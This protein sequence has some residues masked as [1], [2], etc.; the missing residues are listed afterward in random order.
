MASRRSLRRQQ[1]E[2]E[3]QGRRRSLRLARQKAASVNY[4]RS[5][6]YQAPTNSAQLDFATPRTIFKKVLQTQ[7]IVSPLVS[8]KPDSPKPIDTTFNIPGKLS[9]SSIN[10]EVSLPSST[11]RQKTR[12]ARHPTRSKKVRLSEFERDLNNQLHSST[13]QDLLDQTSLTK[14]LQISFTTPIPLNSAGRKGLARYRSV[15]VKDF[16]GGL[17]QGLL[18]IKDPANN[19]EDQ[20]TTTPQS[21]NTEAFS[22]ETELFLPP[23]SS[24][25]CDSEPSNV[26]PELDLARKPL[27]PKSSPSLSQPRLAREDEISDMDVETEAEVV[28]PK[29]LTMSSESTVEAEMESTEKED[30]PREKCP[31]RPPDAGKGSR[32]SLGKENLNPGREDAGRVES[33]SQKRIA[34]PQKQQQKPVLEN[35]SDEELLIPA[36]I[37]TKTGLG[38]RRSSTPTDA[39]LPR[40]S[41]R[42]FSTWLSRKITRP[43][44]DEMVAQF[45]KELDSIFPAAVRQGV[46]EVDS[47]EGSSLREITVDISQ[48]PGV[49]TSN[50]RASGK[51]PEMLEKTPF[52]AVG[53]RTN[54]QTGDR[55]TTKEM[56]NVETEPILEFEAIDN[57][58]FAT[59]VSEDIAVEISQS[60]IMAT[61]SR[62]ASGRDSKRLEGTPFTSTRDRANPQT[63]DRNRRKEMRSVETAQMLE[64]E[65]EDNPEFEEMSESED[66]AVEIPQSPRVATSGRRASG[67]DSKR[68]EGT[69]FTST[70]DRTN[71]HTG[72]RNRRKE[73]RSVETEQ[74]LEVEAEGNPEFEMSESEDVAVEIRQSPRVATS[75]RRASGRDSKRL[76][77]T[78]FT[79]TRDRTNPHTGDRNRRK[80][81]RNVE[82][83]QILEFEPESNSEVEEMSESVDVAV[84]IRQSPR[85]STS[86][87]RASG[88]DSKR[89]EGT[90]FTSTRDRTNPQTGDRSRT[91]GM[92]NVETEQMLEF[93]AEDNPESEE[94]SESEDVAV[95]IPQRPRVATS[96]RRASG[97]DSKRLEGTPFTSTRDRTNPQTGDRNRR[98]EMRN[99]ETEQILEFEAEENP[100]F[101]EMSES[102]DVAVDIPQRPRVATSGRRAS[103]RDSKRLEGTPFT[104]TRD[105]TNPHTA[106]EIPQSPIM[107]TSGRRASGRD[108]KRLEGTPFTS[109]RDRTNPQTGDRNRRKEMRNV[110]TEQVLEVE[111]ESNPEFEEMSESEDVAVD[112]PQSPRV[113]TSGRRASGRDSKKL[114]GTFTSA[115]DRT[116]PH[117]AVEIPQSPRVATSGRRASGRDSKRLEGTPFTSTRDRTNPHTGDRNRRKEMRSVETEQMLEVEAEGNPEFEM[118]ESEDVAV[119]IPQSPR[120]ATSGRR[121]SG[122]DS[123]KLEGTFTSARDRTNP[124]TAVEIPQSPRVA[125]SGRRAS[126]RDSKRL[127]GTPFTST[128]DRTNPHTGDRNRRKEMRSV[129]TEQMLEVEAEGNPEFEMSESEDVA[130]EIRQSPRVST[131]GRR[132]SGRDSK[133]LEGTPFTSTRDRTNPQTG[134]RSRTA[135]MR[136]VETE[137]ML[138]FEPESNSEVEEM[139]ESEDVAVE[140]P[141]SPRVATSGKRASG[142]DSKR[143]ERTPFTSTRD[144]TNPQTGDRN[145]RKEMRNVETEQMLEVEA[146]SNPE[147]E[148]M[149]ESEDVAVEIRQSPRVATS[150]RRASGRDSKRLEGTP[151]TS[152]RD[153]TNPHTGDRN[154]RKEMRSVETAQILVFEAEDNPEF[155]MSESEDVAV[156]I[157]QSPRVATSGRR[158]SGRDSKRL[159]GTLLKATRDRTNPQTADRNRRKEMRNVETAQILVFE[160]KDNPE[161]EMSES[162]DVAVEFPQSPRVATSGRR[163]SGRDSKRL[164]GIPF[165]P[166]RGRTNPQTGDRNRRK[167]MRSVETEQILEFEAE[168]NSDVEEMSESEDIEPMGST[169]A[170]V[171]AKAFHCTPLLSSPR[172]LKEVA[173]PG[174]PVKQNSVQRVLKPAKKASRGKRE[175][176][177]PRNLVKKMFSHYVKMPV[178]KEAFQVMD[179]CVNVYFKHLSSD[180]EAYVNHARRKTAEAADLELL[181]RRQGLITDKTPLNVLVER[182][183]PLE[184]RKLLIP[185]AISGNKV[186]PQKLK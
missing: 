5:L 39:H 122:R 136:I 41:Q 96:G 108:S 174:L 175:P 49:A 58:E 8:E 70:R 14:S 74:M 73:M 25:G 132:A 119:D 106:V 77:G 123:K 2:G 95:D 75:G 154:S 18:Q 125:T 31:E 100:E 29:N 155:E 17:E 19:P 127:E 104:S 105:R 34:T 10:L 30:G 7:S 50:K 102:E 69:P 126:G 167:E 145:R 90:P 27:G 4:Q 186:V 129:E 141:Q 103:G 33:I 53:D 185:I 40:A 61:S 116:N 144:R 181:M 137:Q 22:V 110:E 170:F 162:E 91:A 173:P 28:H 1:P 101:E 149:S 143:L 78:P 112:I 56:K 81:M 120:V 64:F 172:V 151:F 148:E 62:C 142:R 23:H 160:A 168:S 177:L 92:R 158:A 107:A 51:P 21:N 153:R 72:D 163:A 113:A 146:E 37:P 138:E 15:N 84:E 139:S 79:S 44:V 93:E 36:E 57:P 124:H 87:R 98:K 89:L 20:K 48:S 76:E 65:A 182:H 24:E 180:L 47:E 171:R 54:P 59:S 16:E 94:M 140:I 83:E 147:V 165:T 169:P 117:T 63:G 6:A 179:R 156:D 109:T 134:D 68:L 55:N 32:A 164:E 80:E 176:S 85:V 159:E 42:N 88:R 26:P 121:A 130:V 157:T 131:S 115:R 128:R 99:V 35:S 150:G 9:S 135:G 152:M 166:T 86:G 183:L 43:S 118:S 46:V 11:K 161:F 45:T 12:I 52:K 178:T 82:T 114:E 71:P 60:P 13:A 133:R 38:T 97:R 184:Y 3:P 111:D 67:M 66:F